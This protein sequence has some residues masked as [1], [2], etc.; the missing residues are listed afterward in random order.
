MAD[1]IVHHRG[2]K[3]VKDAH[4][5]A[6]CG[7]TAEQMYRRLG[8]KLLKLARS[9]WFEMQPEKRGGE[10]GE[11]RPMIVFTLSGVITMCAWLG[12]DRALETGM[13]LA[14]LLKNRHRASKN[15]ERRPRRVNDPVRQ[16]KYLSAAARL[17][18]EVS[19]VSAR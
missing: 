5:A 19:K 2:R 14:P 13:A 3:G 4:F 1:L 8:E 6:E 17:Q 16:E 15:K 11:S 9:S 18:A 12:T 10:T 7:F